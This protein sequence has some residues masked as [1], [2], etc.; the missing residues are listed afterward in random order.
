MFNACTSEFSELIYI[1][2]YTTDIQ[3]II[4][5]ILMLVTYIE[6]QHIRAKFT[7]TNSRGLRI[8]V[9]LH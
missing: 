2:T 9:I 7:I 3:L 5:G 1:L 8:F 6:L 4:L